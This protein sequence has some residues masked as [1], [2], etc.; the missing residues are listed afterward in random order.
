MGMGVGKTC[1]KG[2][3]IEIA[4]PETTV[5]GDLV[6]GALPAASGSVQKPRLKEPFDYSQAAQRFNECN[7]VPLA[8]TANGLQSFQPGDRARTLDAVC[9][10]IPADD[11]DAKVTGSPESG[12]VDTTTEAPKACAGTELVQ[13]ESGGAQPMVPPADGRIS[14]RQFHQ[15]IRKESDDITSNS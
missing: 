5:G 4:L 15:L 7:A 10:T 11:T 13:E 3:C 12:E 9:Q 2:E 1:C 14:M 6:M 8:V